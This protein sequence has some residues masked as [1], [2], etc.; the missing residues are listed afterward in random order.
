MANISKPALIILCL[1]LAGCG[2]AKAQSDG[3]VA[4]ETQYRRI[5]PAQAQGMMSEL[6]DYILLDVR[7]QEEYRERR[8]YGAVLIPDSELVKRVEK[9]LTDKNSVILVYCR[10]GRRSENAARTLLKMGYAN[11]YDFGGIMNWPYE[12]VTD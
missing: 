11:V 9:E 4:P 6:N 1:T 10:S 3:N 5:T 7:T 12:T 8:I 2:R